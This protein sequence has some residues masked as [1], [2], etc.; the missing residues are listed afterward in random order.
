MHARHAMW[1]VGL[2]QFQF[3]TVEPKEINKSEPNRKRKFQFYSKMEPFGTESL[4]ISC[5]TE[6]GSH[7]DDLKHLFA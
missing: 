5:P 1:R 7:N 4:Q 2:S 3:W 6:I